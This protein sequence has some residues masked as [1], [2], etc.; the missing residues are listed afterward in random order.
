MLFHT[1][2]LALVAADARYGRGRH[3]RDRRLPAAAR[4]RSRQLRQGV[5]GRTEANQ[6][7]LRHE[8][9]QEGTRQRRRGMTLFGI[10]FSHNQC[11]DTMQIFVLNFT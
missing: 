11:H 1:F 8:G 9:H 3:D 5:C 10:L 2:L 6:A 7:H 4:D